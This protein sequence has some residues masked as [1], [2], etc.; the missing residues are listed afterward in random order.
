MNNRLVRKILII[1]VMVFNFRPSVG[2]LWEIVKIYNGY[3]NSRGE[4][5]NNFYGN[6]STFLFLFRTNLINYGIYS[7]LSN[8]KG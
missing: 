8:L 4:K 2:Y 1:A 5:I 6:S 7:S 3:S